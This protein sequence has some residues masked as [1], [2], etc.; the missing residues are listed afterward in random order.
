MRE[1]ERRESESEREREKSERWRIAEKRFGVTRE[2]DRRPNSEELI[3][4]YFTRDK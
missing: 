2:F 3:D 1:A 4:R